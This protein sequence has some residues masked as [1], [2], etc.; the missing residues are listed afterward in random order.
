M[1]DTYKSSYHRGTQC[2]DTLSFEQLHKLFFILN[3]IKI[4]LKLHRDY[5]RQNKANL[6]VQGSIYSKTNKA[7]INWMKDRI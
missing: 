4:M 6:A 5:K 1:Y 3:I 7:S 2:K